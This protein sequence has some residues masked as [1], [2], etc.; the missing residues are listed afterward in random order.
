[1]SEFSR[2]GLDHMDEYTPQSRATM[3]RAYFAYLQNNPGSARAVRELIRK[4]EEATS[5]EGGKKTSKNGDGKTANKSETPT[6][7]DNG[8]N[9]KRASSDVKEK[10]EKRIE[11]GP[12][13]NDKGANESAGEKKPD[14]NERN[15]D[16]DRKSVKSDRGSSSSSADSSEKSEQQ[17]T[18]KKRRP[19]QRIKNK[20]NQKSDNK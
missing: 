18:K 7:S 11:N 1:V 6:R 5:K 13:G 2:R 14:E 12:T 15:E 16:D 9:D 3:R 17:K 19:L 4:E 20:R 10:P 8:K